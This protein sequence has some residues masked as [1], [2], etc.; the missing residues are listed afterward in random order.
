M[1]KE[2]VHASVAKLQY[3]IGD[4]I[5]QSEL[6][7]HIVHVLVVEFIRHLNFHDEWTGEPA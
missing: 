2:G 1:V 3:L 4:R 5:L 7:E 6:L